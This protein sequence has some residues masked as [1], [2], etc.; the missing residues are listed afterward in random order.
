MDNKEIYGVIYKIE[1]LV[2]G[3]VYIGQT[4]TSFKKR[5]SYGGKTD[6]ERV[7]KF[8]LKSKQNKT[9]YNIHLLGSIEKYGFDVWRVNKQFDVAFS[10]EELDIKEQCWI[11]IYNSTDGKCGYN[12]RD[13]GANGKYTEETKMKMRGENHHFYNVF[14]KDNPTSKEIICLN[15]LKSFYGCREVCEYYSISNLSMVC[16]CCNFG[17]NFIFKNDIRLVF[18]YKEDFDKLN[19]NDINKY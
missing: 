18:R 12:N 2:N 4:V 6:I 14:G 10:K 8:H 3:K 13:G 9:S 11:N 16:D 15:D 5:Y 19:K 17:R 1:N 7:Y